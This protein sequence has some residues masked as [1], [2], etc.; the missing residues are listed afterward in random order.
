MGVDLTQSVEGFKTGRM[1]STKEEGSLPG[2]LTL[3]SSYKISSSPGL[4]PAGLPCKF[5]ICQSPHLH[6]PIP[7]NKFLSKEVVHAKPLSRVWL[8]VTPCTVACQAPLS[9]G[10]SRQ[11]NTGVGCHFLLQAKEADLRGSTGLVSDHHNRES[12]TIKWATRIFWFPNAKKKVYTL[13]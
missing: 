13:L 6:E 4:Q 12:I 3:N 1:R 7:L 11:K 8:F 10:F 5:W 9:V 2:H